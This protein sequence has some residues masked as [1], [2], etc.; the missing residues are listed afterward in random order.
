MGKISLFITKKQQIL[1][2]ELFTGTTCI[3]SPVVLL[4]MLYSLQLKSCNIT[5][6]VCC[7]IT[8]VLYVC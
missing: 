5:I 7:N 6:H 4:L 1:N 3:K 2:W 8:G